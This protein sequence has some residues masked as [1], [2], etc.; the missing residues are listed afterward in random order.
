MALSQ[1]FDEAFL[2][3]HSLHRE[4]TRKGS[5][6]PY[7]THLLSV[8]A[9]V[10]EY[11]GTETQ[12]IAALLHDAAEDQGGTDTLHEIER[13]FGAEVAQIVH[14]C[15]DTVVTPKPPWRARKE[16]YLAQLLHEPQSV[17][18][19]SAC[20]KL[21]NARS[22]ARDLRICGEAVW[23]RFTGGKSGSLWYYSSLVETYRRCFPHPV[24]EELD[25]TIQQIKA[26]S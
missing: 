13:R 5:D 3:A 24:V 8:A 1:K 12:Q 10:G 19:V 16:Q 4:Q 14:A 9:L 26:Y 23:D 20:D 6:I 22:I 21:H 11:G 18:L 15:S 17:Q 7:M 25:E 2:F